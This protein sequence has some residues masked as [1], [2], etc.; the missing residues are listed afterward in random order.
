[1]NSTLFWVSMLK[2]V[3]KMCLLLEPKA[4]SNWNK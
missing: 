4:Q 2:Q 3:L 1:M